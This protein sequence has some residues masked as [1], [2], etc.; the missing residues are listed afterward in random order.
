M[1][2]PH[3]ILKYLRK[4]RIAW[5]SLI[6]VTLCV[7]MVLVVISVMGGWLRMFRTSFHSLT[8][9]VLVTGQSLSGFPYYQQIIDDVKKLP[10]VEAA[11]P[12]IQT[13]GLI[14]VL[15]EIRKGVQVIGVRIDE[16]G[17]VNRFDDSLYRQRQ[18]PLEAEEK[19]LK[20]KLSDAEKSAFLK[21]LPPPSFD[22]LPDQPYEDWTRAKNPRRWPGMIVGAGTVG[23]SKNQEGEINRPRV[24]LE[25]WVKL[26]V[27]GVNETVGL[28][29]SSKSERNYW[30]VDDSR[31]QVWQYDSNTVYV[32]FDV[33]QTDLA[34]NAFTD[35]QSGETFPAKA[36]DIQIKVKPGASLVKV[37]DKVNRIVR[38]VF[39]FN[40]VPSYLAEVET[41]EENQRLW[42]GAIEKEVALV[43]FLFGIISLVA[44]FLIFCIFYMIV[45][46]KT[47]DIG[48]I[49]SVGATSQ[50]VAGI[51][52]GYG[53]AIG[54]VGSGLGFLVAWGIVTWI[55][56]LHTWMGRALK[57]QVWDPKVYAFDTIPNTMDPETVFWILGIGVVSSVAGALVPAIRAARMN[58]VEA[59][60]WE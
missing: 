58:P 17:Q 14:N 3:L 2:I 1:Y 46:E 45:A 34:M 27:M 49:K 15:N 6:A 41:W 24:L 32:P 48:I 60:R 8:G 29:A 52:I 13:F 54:I 23:L 19:R 57:L 36:T 47:K 16:A 28:D 43:T 40:G 26:T 11:V 44:V 50:G 37:R 4:R 53:L 12:K 22:L 51:F 33:L 5:V 55:N 18:Q 20:R 38:R 30:I 25:A 31:T 56:E 42:L 59:L 35:P 10:E 39:K 9:D 21:K 7:A